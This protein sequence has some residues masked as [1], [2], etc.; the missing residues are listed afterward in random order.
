M[1]KR[2]GAKP[3]RVGV[4]SKPLP[5]EKW[6]TIIEA[7]MA[8]ATAGELA[9]QH[10]VAVQSIYLRVAGKG[11]KTRRADERAAAVRESAGEAPGG[12]R[13]PRSTG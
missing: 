4:R 5:K 9:L 11:K 13:G 10:G 1:A 12:P 8:G 7:Y 2:G 3:S 6:A